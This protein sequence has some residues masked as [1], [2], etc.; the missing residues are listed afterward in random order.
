[1]MWWARV[2]IFGIPLAA[3]SAGSWAAWRTQAA[4]Q[5]RS[6]D[7][8]VMLPGA[9]PALNPFQPG[10][11]AERQ[12]LDLLHEPLLRLGRD[13]RFGPALA[14]RWAWR[15]HV[16]CWFG[17]ADLAQQA[18]RRLKA[19]SGNE[20]V[21]AQLEE[22]TAEGSAVT[23]RFLK[24]DGPG[25]EEA[26]RSI[27]D[28]QPVR[29]ALLRLPADSSRQALLRSF[30]Q[31]R[32]DVVK[33]LW[34]DGRGN[35]E[36]VA[37]DPAV[38]LQATLNQW[39]LTHRHPAATVKPVGEVT[40]LVEPVLEFRLRAQAR[41]HDGSAVTPED[42][43]ATVEWV[44]EHPEATAVGD[45]FQQVQSIGAAGPDL[46]R[47]TY[48]SRYGAALAAWVNFPILPAA[49]LRAH[50]EPW[51]EP[52]P[53][54]GEYH[55]S[56]RAADSVTLESAAN[57]R[58]RFVAAA[59]SLKTRVGLAAKALDILWPSPENEADLRRDRSLDFQA[60][61]PRNRLL[62][63]WN[64]RSSVLA[65]P[66]V[67][68][69]LALATDRQKLIDELL[70][71]HGRIVDGIFP[72]GIW[73]NQQLSMRLPDVAAAERKLTEAGWLR[74]VSGVAKT[75]QRPL[76]F[77]L[78]I[79]AG[80]PW[81]ERLARALAQQWARVGARVTVSEVDSEELIS[82]RLQPGR[83]DAVLLGL[84]F[85]NTW[86]QSA[87]WH[88]SEVNGG[89]N[90]SGVAEP[91]LDLLLEALAGEY[92]LEQVGM[93][94][95]AV[96]DLLLSQ[97]AVMPLFSDLRQMAIRRERFPDRQTG[98]EGLMLR[99]LLRPAATRAK[100]ALELKMI[101]PDE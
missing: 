20:W 34:F 85:E 86:D 25:P 100:A 18:A 64:L 6:G 56:A 4:R 74:D 92:E 89:L 63:L 17:S 90:F 62:V 12:M 8:V 39:L 47:I 22:A 41:W 51:T 75:A 55:L 21:A 82:R 73:Y 45:D 68:E 27:A 70:E 31:E 28:L 26:L 32:A 11:E 50:G 54:A 2:L 15:R 33:R 37:T 88:S 67:R 49:W 58:L 7:I 46:V 13:G 77:E 87:F 30:A 81:R 10:D 91:Q 97:H 57:K 83:F 95:K 93:R 53:G 19:L 5:S 80:N 36:M 96:E 23:M 43:R 101:M 9:V 60:T 48:R 38:R 61:P 40:G 76:E 72:P 35:C 24:P 29:L 3:L 98:R 94:A 44:T 99:E 71:G 1:M 84:D 14:E 42:V 52:P 16:T 66:R 65:D 79:T 78:L 59:P 69:A